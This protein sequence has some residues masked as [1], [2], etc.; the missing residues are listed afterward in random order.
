MGNGIDGNRLGVTIAARSAD[1]Y[2]DALLAKNKWALDASRTVTYSF[3][4]ARSS[5]FQFDEGIA[6]LNGNAVTA[7][8][9]SLAT[10]TRQALAAYSNVA[11]IKFAQVADNFLGAGDIRVTG[12]L[13]SFGNIAGLTILP[14]P[15]DDFYGWGGDVFFSSSV[16]FSNAVGGFGY[17]TVLHELGH[18]LGLKHPGNYNGDGDGTP[19][20]FPS[21]ALDTTAITVMSYNNDARIT[22]YAS[23]PGIADIRALQHLYGANMNA[24]P[25][26]N[27]YLLNTFRFSSIWDPNGINTLDGN[28][29]SG[30]QTI[31]LNEYSISY[32]DGRITGAVAQGTKIANAIGGAGA[33][34]LRGNDLD[35]TL[36]GSSGDD[37]IIGGGGLDVAVY[38][39]VR[40]H[41]ALLVNPDGKSAG[42]ASLAGFP[43]DGADQLIGVEMLRFADRSVV[44]DRSIIKPVGVSIA[45]QLA[46]VYLGRG[47]G[48]EYRDGIA[49][50]VAGGPSADMQRAFFNAAIND[51]VFT[52][53]DSAQTVANKT[54]LNIFGVQASLFEQTAWAN[55]VSSGAVAK[56]QLP[57][58]MFVSYL[59]ATNV[60]ASYQV[61]AQS[62]IIAADAFSNLIDAAADAKLGIPG[63]SNAA[64]ARSWLLSIRTQADAARKVAS[65]SADLAT[66]LTTNKF[67]ERGALDPDA[68][69]V[70]SYAIADLGAIDLTP[71]I[72]IS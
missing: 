47:V 36:T 54:F 28:G 48:A 41:Y 23:T 59:G 15:S 42:V 1:P 58:V 21:S 31:D 5:F 18:A 22:G 46:V 3:T 26:D 27:T 55:A 65:A 56:E 52:R 16:V 51:G 34:I 30:N 39:G 63:A 4:A 53:F 57:W 20:F 25:G 60:P 38:S 12:S 62:R 11:N 6:P 68:S 45:D 32:A 72:G 71:L 8:S 9:S 69:S 44:I 7:A 19:P 17:L 49:A 29:V 35:N 24:A 67:T 33:D 37:Q 2:V 70:D 61:P 64:A 66:I 14:V 40:S 43:F 50:Q 10:A 13:T